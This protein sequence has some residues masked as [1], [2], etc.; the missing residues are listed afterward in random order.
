MTLPESLVH[1]IQGLLGS[2]LYYGPLKRWYPN[3]TIHGIATQKTSTRSI[4]RH[5]KP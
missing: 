1:L 4:S 3:T 2:D 5:W